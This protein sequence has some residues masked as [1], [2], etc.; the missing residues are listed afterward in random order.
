M[1]N[2]KR[3]LSF[4][5]LTLY[6]IG[7]ILGAGI[8]V[9]I[10][11][12]AGIAGNAVWI[13]FG[14]AAL[15]AAF[16]GLSYAEL[17]GMF[18]RTAAEYIYTKRAFGSN[19]LA[20]AV[21]WTMLFTL[22]VSASTVALG[23]GG[24]LNFLTGIGT[25]PAA[26]GLLIVLSA[27]NYIGIK[28]S[29]RFNV[30]GS[31]V[32]TSGLLIVVLIGAMFFGRTHVDYFAAPAG[33]TGILSAT[34]LIFFAYIGFEEMVNL[35]EETKNAQKV[36]PRALLTALFISTVLYMLVSVSS[37]TV[38]GADALANSQAPM[39]E[40]VAAAIPQA[41]LM[42][43]LI[44][45]FAT[46]NTVLAILVVASRMLY[47]LSC[48][49]TLPGIC[50]LVG[51]RGTPYA[52]VM[53]VMALSVAALLIG[54]I[55]TIALLTDI[56]VFLVY[57]AIN[58]ALITLRYKAPAIERTFRSP[59]SI[60]RFPILALLGIVS[61]GVL[62]LHFEPKLLLYEA[63]IVA[64]GIVVYALF[65]ETKKLHERERKYAKLFRKSIYTSREDYLLRTLI[66][67]PMQVSEV[68][69]RDVR[70]VKPTDT[71]KTAVR[72]MNENHI[73]SVVVSDEREALGIITER[74]ILTRVVGANKSADK[75]KCKEI[76]STP[77]VA[78]D[79]TAGV[80]DAVDT[81]V[82]HRVKRLIVLEGEELAGIITATD[83]L[84]SGERLEQ[85]ALEKLSTFFGP[86][87]VRGSAPGG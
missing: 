31:L 61:S 43:T 45:L 12:G 23:F 39:A 21:Q 56:G 46:S 57:I 6:G 5:T 18:P 50:S 72:L 70:T 86:V 67:Y 83:I 71:V 7:I 52:S 29:A 13:S 64:S 81:M 33:V 19:A 55:K 82:K 20:F 3:E 22:I 15:V 35:A 28:E 34:A 68:M 66:K 10:G 87:Y 62:L 48:N 37:V 47:G 26:V 40:V 84:K 8:Y 54:D 85:E 17:A 76:M 16:T 65:T 60:G 25:F 24:Y 53:L 80:A 14:A 59:L 1:P 78:V 75:M 32:E 2:L 69:T 58:A 42:M 51:K 77:L 36:V 79:A 4:W 38:L 41:K 30:L 74:D 63:A 11:K 73:G 49:N 44:A 27:I 9:L